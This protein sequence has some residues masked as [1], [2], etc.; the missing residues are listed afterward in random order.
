MRRGLGVVV[1]GACLAA[2]PAAAARLQTYQLAHLDAEEVVAALGPVLGPEARVSR[3]GD[4]LVVV[5]E[6]GD[7]GRVRALLA[8]LDRPPPEYRIQVLQGVSRLRARALASPGAAVYSAAEPRPS[9]LRVTAGRPARIESGRVL[10]LYESVYAGLF[11]FGVTRVE[12]PVTR[13]FTVLATPRGERVE[14]RLAPFRRDP[15]TP[16]AGDRRLQEAGTYVVLTPGEWIEIGGG[17]PA[18]ERAVRT[19]DTAPGTEDGGIL[20]RIDV[21]PPSGS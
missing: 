6:D 16:E 3:L 1:L 12:R 19:Y 14:L 20:V 17:R 4:A 11:G 15:G 13:G 10:R 8:R 9:E 18:E 7:H 21:V 2:G 5:A